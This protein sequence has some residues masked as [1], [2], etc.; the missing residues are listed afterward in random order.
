MVI[1]GCLKMSLLEV[2]VGG[3]AP[4]ISLFRSSRRH[5]AWRISSVAVRMAKKNG[6]V[7]AL[8]RDSGSGR[9]RGAGRAEPSRGRDGGGFAAPRAQ[10][11]R[12]MVLAAV[13]LAAQALIFLLFAT[14]RI[15]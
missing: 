5:A 13:V 2:V 9:G 14:S 8:G 4:P 3:R 1:V 15:G 10:R 12:A 6:A 7:S 11:L